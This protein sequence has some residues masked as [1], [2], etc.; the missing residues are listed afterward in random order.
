ML[1]LPLL[2]LFLR[3]IP[4]GFL[5]IFSVYAFSKTVV[6]KKRYLISSI[7]FL[8]AV[9][10][11]RL[12]PI[13]FA[14]HTIL[15][16]IMTIVLT[17]NINKIP[18]IKSIQACIVATI[19]ESICEGLNIFMIQYIFKVDVNYVFNEP[20]LKIVFGIPSL[21]IFAC[22]AIFY[23]ISKFKRKELRDVFNGEIS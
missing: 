19:V 3:G 23:Y 16:L 15:G 14:V 2:E 1:K 4:E 22:I 9:Y 6:N 11:I 5:I 12:L 17:V 7:I 10:L 18:I 21:L 13:Q 20:T 8:V